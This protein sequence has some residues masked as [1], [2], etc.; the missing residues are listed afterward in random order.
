MKPIFA[1]IFL[2]V[3]FPLFAD[4]QQDTIILTGLSGKYIGDVNKDGIPDGYGELISNFGGGY[5]GYWK[6]GV[7][8]GQGKKTW[9]TGDVYEGNWK[10]GNRH[11]QGKMIW[12]SSMYYK[13]EWKNDNEHGNGEIIYPKGNS[14][15]GKWVHGKMHGKGSYRTEPD[16]EPHDDNYYH[17]YFINPGIVYY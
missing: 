9:H 6:N 5:I 12:V 17:G 3:L 14:R 10:F 7:Y 2:V 11:G 16:G 8:H 15:N 1:I 4:A 13:G